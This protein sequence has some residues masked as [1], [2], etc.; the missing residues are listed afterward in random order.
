VQKK[1]ESIFSSLGGLFGTD[2]ETNSES[3]FP[4]SPHAESVKPT[5]TLGDDPVVSRRAARTKLSPEE[6][7]AQF[8]QLF[9]D[10]SQKIGRRTQTKSPALRNSVWIHLFRLA[11][12]PEQLRKVAEIF[13]QWR[14]SRREFNTHHAEMFAC[15]SFARARTIGLK[16]QLYLIGRCD[17]LDTPTL[18]LEVFGNHPKYGI[19]LSLPAARLLLYS[20]HVKY[21]LQDAITAAALY[22]VYNLPSISEDL[23]SCSMLA[24]ACFNSGSKPSRRVANTLVP[25]LRTMLEST[26]PLPTSMGRT[27]DRPRAWLMATLSEIEKALID[28]DPKQD[29]EWLVSW[30]RRSE[31]IPDAIES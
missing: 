19:P 12:T 24:R 28:T 30:R 15:K 27:L 17:E 10:V 3:M 29:V 20:L 26:E 14:E 4:D 6:Q 9:E 7:L 22:R 13:P 21:P 31:H 25:H 5:R 1:E 11:T 16:S 2:G 23:V 8:D 18:A